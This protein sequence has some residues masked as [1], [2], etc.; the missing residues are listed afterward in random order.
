MMLGQKDVL[1][2]L[3]LLSEKLR[4]EGFLLHLE[5]KP[6]TKAVWDFTLDATSSSLDWFELRPGDPL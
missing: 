2:V 1:C 6:I 3:P 5:G 4:Q